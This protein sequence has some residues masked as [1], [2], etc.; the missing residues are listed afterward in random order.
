[1]NIYHVFVGPKGEIILPPELRESLALVEGDSLILEVG[2]DGKIRTQ[3]AERVVG[4]LADFFEDLILSDLHCEGC[5]G[6]L[7]KDQLYLRKTRLSTVL[8]RLTEEARY[9]KENGQGMD[10]RMMPEL[11]GS[12]DSMHVGEFKVFISTRAERDLLKLSEALL[13]EVSNVF[14]M[15]ERNPV[16]F[17]RLR[18]P[19]YET[20]RVSFNGKM[21]GQYRVIYT[22]FEDNHTVSV[23]SIGE[24][25][26][27]YNWLKGLA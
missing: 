3:A 13:S 16:G 26:E 23:L 11:E 7:L 8:D 10:W 14:E 6:D 21:I 24:R 20:Y 15:L 9:A 25:K 22:V 5:S 17:K 12:L 1:M 2:I 19:Y 18:G 4:P 27:I